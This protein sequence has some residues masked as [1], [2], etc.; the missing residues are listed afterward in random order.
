MGR[1][2]QLSQRYFEYFRKK[3]QLET[4]SKR[5]QAKKFSYKKQFEIMR[6]I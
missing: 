6:K 2:A 4:V 5:I 3:H 1:L